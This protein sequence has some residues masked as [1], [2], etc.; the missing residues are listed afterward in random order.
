MQ[1]VKH[2]FSACI[3]LLMLFLLCIYSA[4]ADPFKGPWGSHEDQKGMVERVN[5]GT[6]PLIAM[7]QVYRN[8]ISPIHGTRCPM[9]PSCSEYSLGSL[10]KH[11]FFMGWMMTCDR[12][13]RCGRDELHLSPEIFVNGE[14][15]CFDPVEGNDFWWHHEQ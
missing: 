14:E 15:R 7:V 13:L 6:N 8:H 11:G 5:K 10:E 2:V 1:S 4:C 12:L 3:I 9:Y